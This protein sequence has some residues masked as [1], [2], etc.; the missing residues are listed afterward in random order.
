MFGFGRKKKVVVAAPVAGEII[1][2]TAVEDGVFSGKMLGD[3]FAVKTAAEEV[4]APCDGEIIL[5]AET[6]HAVALRQEGMEIL[7]HVGLD[8]VNMNGQGF[9]SLV[10]KGDKVKKGQPL[11]HFSLADIEAAGKD[12]VTILTI[13]NMDKVKNLGKNLQ[14]R[15]AVLEAEMK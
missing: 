9:S 14:D 7:I 12:T 3:G 1:D 11:L 8:T 5:V 6:K 10:Q 4:T 13:T 2:I 15:E